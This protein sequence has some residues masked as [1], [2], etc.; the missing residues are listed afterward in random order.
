[1]SKPLICIIVFLVF[2]SLNHFPSMMQGFYF[3][4]L[5]MAKRLKNTRSEGSIA[6]R[7]GQ[8]MNKNKFC[9]LGS[10][11]NGETPVICGNH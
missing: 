1:M 10:L 4:F 8:V 6:K 3:L 5:G 9:A 11:Y 7:A 2:N